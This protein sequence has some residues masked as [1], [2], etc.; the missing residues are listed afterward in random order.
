MALLTVEGS[1][2]ILTLVGLLAVEGRS[3]TTMFRYPWD[4]FVYSNQ[5]TSVDQLA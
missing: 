1:K 5:L 2:Q 4:R 3:R